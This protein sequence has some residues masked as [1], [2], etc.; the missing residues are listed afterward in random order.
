[1]LERTSRTAKPSF[2]TAVRKGWIAQGPD[3][4]TMVDVALAKKLFRAVYASGRRADTD[5]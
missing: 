4:E 3:L 1:M 5:R 2:E